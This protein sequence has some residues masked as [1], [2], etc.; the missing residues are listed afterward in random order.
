MAKSNRFN[1]VKGTKDF[2][3]AGVVC[4]FICLWSIRDAWFPTEKILKKHPLEFPVTIEVSG[5][6]QD[7]PVDVGDEVGGKSPLLILNSA[8]LEEAVAAAEQAYKDAKGSGHDV[9]KE[10]LDVLMKARDDLDRATVTADDFILKT[11]HGE[12]PLHGKVLD[13]LVE[14]ATEVEAGDTVMLVK[15]KDTFYIFNKTLSV[16]M[17]AAAA[18]FLFFHRVASK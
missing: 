15:P 18:V 6:V 3:V 4:A 12:D 11:T 1:Q 17:F 2:L 14:P 16:L 9:L 10:K 7:I 13:I 5:V 8:H